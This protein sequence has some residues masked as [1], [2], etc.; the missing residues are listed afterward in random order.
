MLISD[1]KNQ[2]LIANPHFNKVIRLINAHM[3]FYTGLNKYF[4]SNLTNVIISD[5]E[6]KIHFQKISGDVLSKEASQSLEKIIEEFTKIKFK[7]SD[8]QE[9]SKLKESEVLKGLPDVVDK[10]IKLLTYHLEI[11]K[12]KSNGLTEREIVRFILQVEDIIISWSNTIGNY[13][14]YFNIAQRYLSN[15]EA[16]EKILDIWL[17]LPENTEITISLTR[18]LIEIINFAAGFILSVMGIK[19]LKSELKIRFFD[20]DKNIFISVKIKEELADLLGKFF[21]YLDAENIKN[22]AVIKHAME[23]IRLSAGEKLSKASISTSSK[24]LIDMLKALPPD[25]HF[26]ICT[27]EQKDGVMVLSSLCHTIEK[28]KADL[29][30]TPPSVTQESSTVNPSQSNRESLSGTRTEGV[31]TNVEQSTSIEGNSDKSLFEMQLNES[32]SGT[33]KSLTTKPD[34]DKKEVDENK[35]LAKQ[36]AKKENT[37]SQQK[38]DVSYLAQL[39]S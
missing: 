10:I 12:Y 32:D 6:K 20:G 31:R 38:R 19:D 16:S 1:I 27:Q 3:N 11:K 25:S 4:N 35:S 18:S 30:Q 36:P 8:D 37:D 28:I 2:I 13:Q 15:N 24:K 26:T 9:I 7:L 39:T 34:N 33:E 17:M 21:H 14:S 5:S 23:T 22:N 29:A